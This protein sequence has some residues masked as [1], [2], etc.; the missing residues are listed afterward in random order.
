MKEIVWGDYRL[1]EA[2]I[3]RLIGEG[4]WHEKRFV[5]H[6]ILQNSRNLLKDLAQFDRDDLKRLLYREKISPFNASF[7]KKRIDIAK[8]Y[9]FNEKVRIKELEW[10]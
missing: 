10:I 7:L 3:K 1:D 9:F 8:N 4:D 5:F 6:K 2:E